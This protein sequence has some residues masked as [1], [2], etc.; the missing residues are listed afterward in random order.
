M[1]CGSINS[2]LLTTNDDS[3][4]A[5]LEFETKEDALTAQTKDQKLYGNNVIEVQIGK[6]TTLYVANFPPTADEAYI[7]ELFA[8]VSW[9][10]HSVRQSLMWRS[11]APSLTCG[12]RL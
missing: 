12:S 6:G 4:T 11:T 8:K 3:T 5:T 2:V 7:K 1:Q 10:T 9:V